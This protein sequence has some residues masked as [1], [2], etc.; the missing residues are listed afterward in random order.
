[1]QGVRGAQPPA[2]VQPNLSHNYLFKLLIHRLGGCY[3]R[4]RRVIAGCALCVA[5][6]AACEAHTS[7]G[8][9]RRRAR[10][11]GRLAVKAGAVHGLGIEGGILSMASYV[12]NCCWVPCTEKVPR[13]GMGVMIPPL[14]VVAKPSIA[15]AG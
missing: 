11:L 10:A 14:R 1:M 12:A 15:D 2:K 8:G 7:A 4:L 13:G 6:L 3:V 5:L 9:P